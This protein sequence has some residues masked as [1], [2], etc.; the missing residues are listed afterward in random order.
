MNSGTDK[1]TM[2]EFVKSHKDLI[3]WQKSFELTKLI[4][5]LS[6]KL[7]A[8]ENFGLQNQI[9]R[10]AVSVTSNIAEGF[11]RKSKKDREH[12]FTMASG[13]L[14]EV[15]SQ[16]L[17]AKDLGYCREYDYEQLF[18]QMN[19]AHKLVHGLLRAHRSEQ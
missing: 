11:G 4:Y 14:Y 12:F 15:K 13:S 10:A 3:V 17:F 5:K 2:S 7:P 6:E 16:A 1:F 8:K 9:R 18:E 19:I